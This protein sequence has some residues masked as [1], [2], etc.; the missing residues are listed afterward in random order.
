MTPF[1]ILDFGFLILRSERKKISCFALVAMLFALCTPAAAQQTA[2]IKVGILRAR[3]VH[4]AR[5][6]M[7]YCRNFERSVIPREKTFRLN[8]VS[9]KISRNGLRFGCLSWFSLMLI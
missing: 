3:L 6:L 1:W 2:K 4:Q 9:R 7:A 8:L 5:Q